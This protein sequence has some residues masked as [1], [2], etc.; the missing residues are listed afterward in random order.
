MDCNLILISRN[1]GKMNEKIKL[2]KNL[3]PIQ[4]EMIQADLSLKSEVENV[5]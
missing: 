4:I 2:L 1:A 3:Y 5:I